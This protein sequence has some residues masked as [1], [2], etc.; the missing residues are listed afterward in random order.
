MERFHDRT[1]AGRRLGLLLR[2]HALERPV[3]IGLP[4]GGV[5][6]ALEVARALGAP[7]DVRAVRKVGIPGNP[8]LAA[9]AVAEGGGVVLNQ[10]LMSELGVTESALQ[11]AITRAAEDATLLGGRLRGA[12]PRLS[13][14][15]RTV[16]LVDDGLA[17]GATMRA[18]VRAARDEGAR[19]VIAAVPVG[20]PETC[21]LVAREV[22]RLVCPEQPRAFHS[23]G[24]WYDDF[25]QLGDE[26][27]ARMLS[28][29]QIERADTEPQ[30]ALPVGTGVERELLRIPSA[31]VWLEGELESPR[32]ASALVILAHGSGSSRHS[33]RNRFLARALRDGGFATLRLDL[34][35]ERET[36]KAVAGLNGRA[37]EPELGALAGRLTGVVDWVRQAPRFA[38]LPTG[39]LGGSTGAAVALMT[40]AARPWD[41]WAVVSRGGR[42]D[43]AREV[44]AEVRAPT[45]FIVGGRD[46]VVM[47]LNQDA[48]AMLSSQRRLSIVRSA[49]H[50]FEEP[51]ALEE[52]ADLAVAWFTEHM[53]RDA[54]PPAKRHPR[55]R[56]S[57]AE[58]H[59]GM[60]WPERSDRG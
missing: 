48:M 31:G 37:S 39:L 19:S 9:G 1:D 54:A 40:A 30:V 26:A 29:A 10:A 53:P 50:L 21:D 12:C 15:D 2:N 24:L 52:V 7:L 18:A 13:L 20:P 33:A 41:V 44:L 17:T 25:P 22:D 6:V 14:R 34:L 16:V 11:P 58:V 3:V 45:L 4:R 51:G 38:G 57:E 46:A 43:L 27:V 8:E 5:P 36:S 28:A 60:P 35:T 59:A 23:V 32:G 56:D 49:G 42:P 47:S 55:G